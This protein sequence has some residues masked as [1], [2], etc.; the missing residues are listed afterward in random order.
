MGF[1]FFFDMKYSEFPYLH[2]VQVDDS[3]TQDEQE[4]VDQ[5]LEDARECDLP[6][7]SR[8]FRR[9]FPS[10]FAMRQKLAK[11]TLKTWAKG[12]K[13]HTHKSERGHAV[14]RHELSAAQAPG[15]AFHHHGRKNYLGKVRTMHI[16]SNGRDPLGCRDL[17]LADEVEATHTIASRCIGN[18]FAAFLSLGAAADDV[19]HMQLADIPD[20][21]QQTIQQNALGN[22]RCLPLSF[23][24]FLQRTPWIFPPPVENSNYI[25]GCPGRHLRF[26]DNRCFCFCVRKFVQEV[27]ES[28]NNE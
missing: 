14:E 6:I 28:V 18:P 4:E 11:H 21:V 3:F 13:F 12:K 17:A 8:L 20:R 16:S 19:P 22:I 25:V 23:V 26:E 10:V 24:Q 2:H 9:R 15:Q 7:F 1:S 27:S 5:Q